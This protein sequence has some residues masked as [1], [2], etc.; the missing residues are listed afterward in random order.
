MVECQS[1]R[2]ENQL[3][4]TKL[5]VYITLGGSVFLFMRNFFKWLNIFCQCFS[6]TILQPPCHLAKC[7]NAHKPTWQLAKEGSEDLTVRS[8]KMIA[9]IGTV[10]EQ[11]SMWWCGC[12]EDVGMGWTWVGVER[13]WGWVW[14]ER[15]VCLGGISN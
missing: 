13:M 14:V 2:Q 5:K 3:L 10:E 15:M 4:K 7:F 8:S 11:L 12:R 9:S 1:L 6:S